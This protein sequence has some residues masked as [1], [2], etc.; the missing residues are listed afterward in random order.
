MTGEHLPVV[1][2]V[3]RRGAPGEAHAVRW[4]L[5][6]R[7]HDGLTEELAYAARCVVLSRALGLPDD[8]IAP[9]YRRAIEADHPLQAFFAATDDWQRLRRE[10]RAPSAAVLRWREI[11]KSLLEGA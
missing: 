8:R 1:L 9:A 4:A 10:M 5:L 3:A 6:E 2:G 11:G 7:D